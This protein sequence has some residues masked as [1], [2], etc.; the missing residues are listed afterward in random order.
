MRTFP[1]VSLDSVLNGS[2]T[3]QYDFS[4]PTFFRGARASGPNEYWQSGAYGVVSVTDGI[5][6]SYLWI[7]STVHDGPAVADGN[8]IL[9]YTQV[10]N[11]DNPGTYESF[12][13]QTTYYRMQSY[14]PI[15][16]VIVRNYYGPGRFSN[17]STKDNAKG[18]SNADQFIDINYEG[19]MYDQFSVW[20]SDSINPLSSYRS[21]YDATS[22][23]SSQTCTAYRSVQDSTNFSLKAG[24]QFNLV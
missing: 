23:T 7:Q 16:K 4:S 15:E 11:P 5:G 10:E 17:T 12:T 24:K 3:A 21:T 8:I 6:Q 22:K 20:Q 13:C 9:T 14:A 19:L 2:T 1:L 18:T